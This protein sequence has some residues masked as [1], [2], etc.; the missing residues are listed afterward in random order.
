M[1]NNNVE[2]KIVWGFILELFKTDIYSGDSDK[3]SI[4]L[5]VVKVT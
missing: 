3:Y 4:I 5:L 2:N 1:H